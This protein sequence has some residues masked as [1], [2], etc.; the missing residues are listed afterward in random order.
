MMFPP[1]WSSQQLRTSRPFRHRFLLPWRPLPRLLPRLLP[2]PPLKALRAPGTRSCGAGGG[3]G[4]RS[5]P[6]VC[7]PTG[8]AIDR[9]PLGLL[10][11]V[12]I[13]G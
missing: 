10:P 13:E 4:S 8:V 6:T 1:P 3:V 12:C 11:P 2:R 9:S 5:Y 7:R